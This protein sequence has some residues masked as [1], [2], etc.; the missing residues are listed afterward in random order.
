MIE[1]WNWEYHASGFLNYF[2]LIVE[3]N[4]VKYFSE[5]IY[6]NY[7]KMNKSSHGKFIINNNLLFFLNV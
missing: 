5:V 3:T 6:S 7:L 1:I 4:I 2:L